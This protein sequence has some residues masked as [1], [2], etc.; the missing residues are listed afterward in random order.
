MPAQCIS[1]PVFARYYARLSPAM[2]KGGMATHRQQLLQGLTG[3]VIGIAAGNGLSF[4]HYRAD[5][6]HVLAIEADPHLREVAQRT[7]KG[8]VKA[9]PDPH[10]CR[11][12]LSA[13]ACLGRWLAGDYAPAS[14]KPAGGGVGHLCPAEWRP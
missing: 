6:T 5:V 12:V 10:H 2:D 9:E 13:L 11:M 4:A 7:G 3:P 1:H 14:N 8:R